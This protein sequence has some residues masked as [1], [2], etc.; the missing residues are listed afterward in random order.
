MFTSSKR[1]SS[2]LVLATASSTFPI[3]FLLSSS[4]GSCGR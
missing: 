2:S 1:V 4:C 3:T